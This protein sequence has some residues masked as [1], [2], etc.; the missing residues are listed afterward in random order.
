MLSSEKLFLGGWVSAP[1]P[2][3][4][5]RFW[6]KR[7]SVLPPSPV[8][9]ASET[10]VQVEGVDAW[11]PPGH[12]VVPP[13][14]RQTRGR[15][16]KEA[17]GPGR[18]GT[19]AGAAALLRLGSRGRS[20]PCCSSGHG[21]GD[22]EQGPWRASRCRGEGAATCVGLVLFAETVFKL[23]GTS[24]SPA[25]MERETLIQLN[26]GGGVLSDG[27]GSPPWL[28]RLTRFVTSWRCRDA[29][30]SQPLDAGVM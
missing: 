24:R 7:F 15:S 21:D 28:H 18:G 13:L 4:S 1:G 14:G 16:L 2:R 25:G 29:G 12:V 5:L 11:H 6:E 10:H 9:S 27:D 30:L 8:P 23:R 26:C 19:V 22:A 3:W 17:G 20:A